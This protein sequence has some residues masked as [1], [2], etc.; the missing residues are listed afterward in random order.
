VIFGLAR[1]FTKKEKKEKKEEAFDIFL[2]EDDE[3]FSSIKEDAMTEY[4]VTRWYRAPE[5]L[6]ASQYSTAIDI[7]SVGCILMEMFNHRPFETLRKLILDLFFSSKRRNKNKN[8]N[9]NKSY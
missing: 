8:D 9:V 7:W 1:G 6:L 3:A 5:L 2:Q 4:V